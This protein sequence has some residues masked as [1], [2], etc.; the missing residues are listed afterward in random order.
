MKWSRLP[1]WND[2]L[3]SHSQWNDNGYQCRQLPVFI[4]VCWPLAPIKPQHVI[5]CSNRKKEKKK[6]LILRKR[7]GDNWRRCGFEVQRR[8]YS[9]CLGAAVNLGQ[10]RLFWP[11]FSIFSLVVALYCFRCIISALPLPARLSNFTRF[12]PASVP[13]ERKL[14]GHGRESKGTGL[15]GYVLLCLVLV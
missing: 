8:V 4:T 14:Q 5:F 12:E 13:S 15:N 3:I 7:P 6:E 1:D 9:E 2:S 10:G 11:S